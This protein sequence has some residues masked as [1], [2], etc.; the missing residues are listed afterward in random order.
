M[1]GKEKKILFIYQNLWSFVKTDLEILS[2]SHM[3]TKY[4]YKPAKGLIK[5][6]VEFMRQ[7]FYLLFNIWQFD[8]VFIWFADYHS[9][10]PVLFAKI[11][12]KKSFVVIGGYDVAKIPELKYGSFNS[13]FRAFCTKNTFLFANLCLPVANSLGKAILLICPKAKVE[14]VY[15]GHN[16]GQFNFENVEREKVI[17]TLSNTENYQ[18]FL[19]KGLDRFR[20]LSIILK[21]Y[22]FLIIGIQEEAIKLFHP[23]PENLI[24]KPPA[25]LNELIVAFQEAS[26]Y[27]QFSRSEGLPGALCEAMLCG[28][29]PLGANVGDINNVIGDTGF[30]FDDWKPNEI[31]EFINKNQNRKILRHNA[32]ERIVNNFSHSL[33]L[34][35][36]NSLIDS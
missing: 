26:F 35:K 19:I 6:A 24:L 31:I 13:P 3:V 23:V 34:E 11:F 9:L 21:D 28:C 10:L 1:S 25:S 18:R 29:I 12:R 36:I 27:A 4:H 5:N 32:R 17:F 7:F 8:T 15:T 22:T 14:V 2:E 30:V 16:S 20:E 33:R